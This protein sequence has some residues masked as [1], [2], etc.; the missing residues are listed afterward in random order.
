[1]KRKNWKRSLP[2]LLSALIVSSGTAVLSL[3]ANA[4]S[5]VRI[6]GDVNGD[7]MV[8]VTDASAVQNYVNGSTDAIGKQYLRE[9][10]VDGNGTIDA[11]DATSIQNYVSGQTVSYP[12]GQPMLM[13]TRF[14]ASP[15]PTNPLWSS[16]FSLQT[17]Y[18]TLQN[19]Q[20][21]K[22]VITIKQSGQ[23]IQTIDYLTNPGRTFTIENND[24]TPYGV[25]TAVAE[26]EDWRGQTDTQTIEFDMEGSYIG[27]VGIET[28][29]PTGTPTVGIP[30]RFTPEGYNIPQKY[31]HYMSRTMTVKKDGEVVATAND[32]Y[33]STPLTWTPQETGNYTVTFTMS[34][35]GGGTATK[36][37]AVFICDEMNV[38]VSLKEGSQ[39][40]YG[41][42]IPVEITVEGAKP[43]LTYEVTKNAATAGSDYF[44]THSN[45]NNIFNIQAGHPTVTCKT[46]IKVTDALNRV[47]TKTFNYVSTNIYVSSV[48]FSKKNAKPGETINISSTANSMGIMP[49]S[50][51]Y[52]IQKPDGTTE[53]IGTLGSLITPW[54]PSVAGEYTITSN[55]V[56][57]SS[58]LYLPAFS[59]KTVTYTVAESD[60]SAN[61][62]YTPTSSVP[63][64]YSVTL[65]AGAN[66]G[67]GHYQYRFGYTENNQDVILQDY[68]T[69]NVLKYQALEGSHSLFV[70][71]KD[72][73]GAVVRKTPSE[74]ITGFNTEPFMTNVPT[75][76]TVGKPCYF[77]AEVSN[78]QR[79]TPS[80]RFIVKGSN[81]TATSING[82]VAGGPTAHAS[83]TPTEA[84]EYT[85]TAEAVFYGTVVASSTATCT[86]TA[87]T[88]SADCTLDNTTVPVNAPVNIG[89]SAGD[90]SGS[91]TYQ[92]SYVFD[93]TEKTIKKFTSNTNAAFTP[94]AAGTYTIKVTA[95]DSSG[96]TATATK[97]L[98]AADVSLTALTADKAS[99]KVGD[100]VTFTAANDNAAIPVTFDYAVT[101]NG[102]TEKLTTNKSGSAQWTPNAAGNY[103]VSATMC[104]GNTALSTKTIAYSVEKKVSDNL[105]TIYYKGY[106]IPYIEYKLSDG[107][108]SVPVKMVPVSAVPGMTHKY[109]IN[110]GSEKQTDVRFSNGKNSVDDLA[111]E[112]YNFTAGL[113]TFDNGLISVMKDR[114]M[115]NNNTFVS[116]PAV[117]NKIITLGKTITLSC[118]AQGGNGDYQFSFSYKEKNDTSWKTLQ[119]YAA[120][121]SAEFAPQKAGTY[122]ACI[123]AKDASGIVQKKYFKISVFEAVKSVSSISA[124]SIKSGEQVTVNCGAENGSGKFEYS[125]FYKK[126]VSEKWS[127]VQAYSANKTVKVTPSAATVYDIK[128]KVRDKVTGRTD[129]QTFTVTV[130]KE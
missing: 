6:L 21:K 7:G 123:K 61:L 118:T 50:A 32:S 81:G 116:S 76:G 93:G 126:A 96:N 49:I 26:V 113:Y 91:C 97:E 80:Y 95:K 99:A 94:K 85:V 84:G 45:N 34:G 53:T 39:I 87:N 44:I 13:I 2:I 111:G 3:N 88:L 36:T 101:M 65:K 73:T 37:I 46:D 54:T 127:A 31:D 77:S 109:T 66:G 19:N 102:K 90:N 11:V 51:R 89:A 103:V 24:G 75:E 110:M 52:S 83:W 42:A 129:E 33:S 43:P 12:I 115:L 74:Y 22:A 56:Y 69:K 35:Y 125:V 1:M 70:D 4:A 8:S 29:S 67:S 121:G 82:V 119:N 64:G 98:T 15:N 122:L 5:P 41:V 128:V 20:L 100:T 120:N 38:S 63:T 130:S 55:F 105:V 107:K 104:F 124:V 47:Y 92:Y 117:S 71:V 106:S 18:G 17:E 112:N 58:N 48:D 114:T 86:V 28:D 62:S 14:E 40:P 16:S 9:A 30:V 27:D 25:Y 59:T 60:L 79:I 23:I 72:S 108:W 78:A 10:D 57:G 68:S